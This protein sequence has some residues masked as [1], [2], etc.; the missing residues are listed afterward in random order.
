MAAWAVYT[1]DGSKVV[2]GK[3]QA[4]LGTQET[5]SAS[6]VLYFEEFESDIDEAI[7]ER[8]GPSPEGPGFIDDVGRTVSTFNY[9]TEMK[10]PTLGAT[11]A[12]TDVPIHPILHAGQWQVETQNNSGAPDEDAV[13]Y[14]LGSNASQASTF[15]DRS[16]NVDDDNGIDMSLYDAVLTTEFDWQAGE[17]MRVS[18]EG[19][20]RG[21]AAGEVT[22]ILNAVTAAAA[23]PQNGSGNRDV[24]TYSSA[25]PMKFMGASISIYNTATDSFIGGGSLGSPSG[26]LAVNRLAFSP[27]MTLSEDLGAQPE[28]GVQR[29]RARRNQA[30]TV[31]V[32]IEVADLDEIN[33]YALRHAKTPMVLSV[34]ITNSAGVNFQ[35]LGWGVV[36]GVSKVDLGERRGYEMTFKLIHPG[37]SSGDSAAVAGLKPSQVFTESGSQ[38]PGIGFTPNSAVTKKGIAFIGWWITR[39]A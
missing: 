32:G 34:I 16:F 7:L 21:Y 10:W 15:G 1:V 29:L 35:F 30:A 18:G 31:T 24:V 39:Q 38:F 26:N 23:N 9:A 22:D 3:A 17:I 25:D 2:L 6:D 27:G 14:V 37:S 12:A 5:L 13:W 28:D 33:P 4:T 11:P 8:N 19:R 36:T 20:A